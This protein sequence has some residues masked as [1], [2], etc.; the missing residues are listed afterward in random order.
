MAKQA[1]KTPTK[2]LYNEVV[3]H[4]L[5]KDMRWQAKST[6]DIFF[7]FEEKTI[8]HIDNDVLSVGCIVAKGFE[9]INNLNEIV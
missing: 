4:C 9:L 2:E 1:I 3:K 8:I 6:L 7:I 5:D